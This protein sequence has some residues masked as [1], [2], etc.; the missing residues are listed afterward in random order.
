MEFK[1][2]ILDEETFESDSIDPSGEIIVTG[3]SGIF[4]CSSDKCVIKVVDEQVDE[5][6]E[7]S[8]KELDEVVEE[9]CS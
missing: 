8:E 6:S 7:I 5:V 3:G 2:G 1:T 4:I 9:L